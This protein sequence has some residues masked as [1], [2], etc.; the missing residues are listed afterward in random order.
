[1]SRCY[2]YCEQEVWL[3]YNNKALRYAEKPDRQ[4]NP[5]HHLYSSHY[6]GH[7]DS[8]SAWTHLCSD[9]FGPGARESHHPN[10]SAR[11]DHEI[12][13]RV[14]TIHC[15]SPYRSCAHVDCSPFYWGCA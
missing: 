14:S 12:L 10:V 13:S 3:E 1:M 8:E 2:A 6:S 9:A 4:E 7:S 5:V 15:Q 11:S